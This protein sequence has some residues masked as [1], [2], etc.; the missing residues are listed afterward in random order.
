MTPLNDR[1]DLVPQR[2]NTFVYFARAT[3]GLIKIGYSQQPEGRAREFSRVFKEGVNILFTVPGNR[4]Q[5]KGFHKRFR[6][7][8]AHGEWFYESDKLHEFLK[9]KGHGGTKTIIKKETVQVPGPTQIIRVMERPLLASGVP[10]PQK[11]GYARVSTE[12]Q[13]LDM[14]MTALRNAGVEEFFVETISAVAAKRPQFELMLKHLEAGDT[15]VVYSFSRIS[16]DLKFLLTFVDDM[17]KLGVKIISTSEPHIDPYTTNGRL[18]LSV[19][20]AVDENERGRVRDRTRD[21]MAEKKRQGMYLGRPRVV[22][23]KDIPKLQ[24]M[25][26]R[27]VKV[28]LIA[29][30]FGCSIP[31]VYSHTKAS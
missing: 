31:C 21:A 28:P 29:E 2:R 22:A 14:Q 3:S 11:L 27:G 20:G 5:E 16:R 24:A 26:D 15:L 7:S 1:P 4:I 19:T 8:N 30:K 9:A 17:K 10:V 12:D 6:D 13:V 23:L 25:R 18:L